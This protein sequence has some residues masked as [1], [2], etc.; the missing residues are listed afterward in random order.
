MRVVSAI[1]LMAIG[2]TCCGTVR[3]STPTCVFG[4]VPS[5]SAVKRSHYYPGPEYPTPGYGWWADAARRWRGYGPLATG[6]YRGF[7]Y[8]FNGYPAPYRAYK[9][10]YPGNVLGAGNVGN[11]YVYYT[12]FGEG[13]PGWQYW[14][15]RTGGAGARPRSGQHW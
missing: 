4:A 9:M 12:Y 11:D 14:P 1:L 5:H 6:A 3:G 10:G 13:Y 2:A 8:G 15:G 7:G